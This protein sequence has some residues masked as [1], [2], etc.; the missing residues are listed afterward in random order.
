[1]EV[2]C[3]EVWNIKPLFFIWPVK[4]GVMQLSTRDVSTS[5]V[6]HL[7]FKTY[8]HFFPICKV[9]FVF[10][11][12]II[13][14]RQSNVFVIIVLY[15]FLRIFLLE[16]CINIVLSVYANMHVLIEKYAIAL[17]GYIYGCNFV[18][19]VRLNIIIVL[20]FIYISI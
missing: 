9:L 8:S 7:N 18:R 11:F 2:S 3:S 14:F 13:V 20:F 6:M 12:I 4:I 17:D 1:M 10:K 15:L 16:R 19:V 5:K